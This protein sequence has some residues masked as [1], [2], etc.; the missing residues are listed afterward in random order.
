M[1]IQCIVRHGAGCDYH[2][3]VLPFMYIEKDAEW[4]KNH[5]VEMLW[6]AT[7]EHFIHCDVLIYNKLIGTPIDI[8]KELQ[9]KGMKIVVDVD[10]YW[11]LPPTHAN[12]EWNKSGN[13]KL[14]IEHIKMADLVICTSTILQDKIR[15]LNKNT[16]VIPNALP[17][18]EDI[19]TRVMERH[20]DKNK[21]N[22]FYAGGVSHLPDVKLLQP[23]FKN[24]RRD[25]YITSNARFILAGYNNATQKR[26]HTKKDMEM[27]NNNF[28]LVKVDGPYD[29]MKK[30]F[31]YTGSYTVL[32]T[33]PIP[34]YLNYYDQ[35]DIGLIP[36]ENTSWNSMKSTLK[37][38]ECA[39]RDIPAIVSSV[40]PYSDLR[41]CEGIMWVEKPE[42][43]LQYITKCIK[44]PA[45]VKDSGLKMSEWIREEYNLN[46]WNDVRKQVLNSLIC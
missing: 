43:W 10:D 5:T 16:V 13:D 36:L 14:T 18:G 8:L 42:N 3:I 41:P 28:K 22:F 26:Y 31:E 23:T 4:C 32:P 12:Y 35:A 40:S 45:F 25:K 34:D 2:R 7:E 6:I 37:L 21:L 9:S 11:V 27:K 1:K 19:F 30:V 20:N 17:F 33:A 24:I 39:T 15:E 44:E 29:E 46:K 38:L